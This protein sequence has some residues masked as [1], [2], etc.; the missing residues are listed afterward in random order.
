MEMLEELINVARRI[1]HGQLVWE[2]VRNIELKSFIVNLSSFASETLNFRGTGKSPS[3]NPLIR[4]DDDKPVDQLKVENKTNGISNDR[5][6]ET[7]FYIFHMKDQDESSMNE[8]D[9]A[10]LLGRVDGSAL[11]HLHEDDQRSDHGRW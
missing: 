6:D 5:I 9:E 3:M 8:A 1:Y 4:K 11:Y 2:M 10:T 7:Y